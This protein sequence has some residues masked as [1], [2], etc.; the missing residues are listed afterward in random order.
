MQQ[1]KTSALWLC[2]VS[3][4]QSK[5]FVLKER[6]S[7]VA[8]KLTP[9]LWYILYRVLWSVP[10]VRASRY[11]LVYVYSR[12]CIISIY[13]SRLGIALGYGHISL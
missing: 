2:V 5:M 11:I 12:L 3:N 8:E 7:R 9:V 1:Q 4:K 6:T 10:P 13:Y